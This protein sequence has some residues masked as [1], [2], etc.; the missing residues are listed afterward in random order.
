MRDAPKICPFCAETIKKAALKCRYC[1]E[2]LKPATAAL[3]RK[4]VA[5]DY[6]ANLVKQSVVLRP[7]EAAL[8]LLGNDNA[9]ERVKWMMRRVADAARIW[10]S[11]KP[12]QKSIYGCPSTRINGRHY[13]DR[14]ELQKWANRIGFLI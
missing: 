14:V 11:E 4:K 12:N 8:Y 13:F 9:P 5:R 1:L 10:H 7:R 3:E 2:D 6:K